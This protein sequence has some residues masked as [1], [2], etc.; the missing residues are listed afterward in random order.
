[1]EWDT[2]RKL[3]TTLHRQFF[4]YFICCGDDELFLLCW[5]EHVTSLTT[6]TYCEKRPQNNHYSWDQDFF[7]KRKPLKAL[8]NIE[9]LSKHSA[10][11]LIPQPTC[12]RKSDGDPVYSVLSPPPPSPIYVITLLPAK[13]DRLILRSRTTATKLQGSM[14]SIWQL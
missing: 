8:K 7:I 4:I 5:G 12:C 1:M 3:L 14:S 11:S 2:V 10:L 6:H 9:A 13:F